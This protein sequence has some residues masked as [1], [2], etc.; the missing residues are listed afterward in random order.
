MRS[1]YWT[2]LLSNNGFGVEEVKGLGSKKLELIFRLFLPSSFISFLV[3]VVTGK[4]LQYFIPNMVKEYVAKKIAT[5]IM[6]SQKDPDDN[7]EIFEY[8][9]ISRKKP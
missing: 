2:H 3:K 1:L 7:H 8:M 5:L 4:Y 9:I 6:D